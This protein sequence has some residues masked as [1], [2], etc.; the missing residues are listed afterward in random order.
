M[1]GYGLPHPYPP[2]MAASV[3]TFVNALASTLDTP[4]HRM[5]DSGL[6]RVLWELGCRESPLR[7]EHGRGGFNIRD[8]M[9]ALDQEDVIDRPIWALAYMF[10]GGLRIIHH[11]P[12]TSPL[13]PSNWP[14]YPYGWQHLW[15]GEL[16]RVR[17]SDGSARRHSRSLMRAGVVELA[18]MCDPEGDRYL[19]TEEAAEACPW[20]AQ[21]GAVHDYEY[22]RDALM[23]A[24]VQPTRGR[25]PW[26]AADVK[27]GVAPAYVPPDFGQHA[28][29][30]RWRFEKQT[31]SGDGGRAMADHLGLRDR[32]E[33]RP[34][35]DAQQDSDPSQMEG[36][37][38]AAAFQARRRATRQCGTCKSRISPAQINYFSTGGVGG[39]YIATTEKR[40]RRSARGRRPVR[41][42]ITMR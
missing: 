13:H 4:A 21:F 16:W 12:E 29:E 24:G 14:G 2:M 18:N 36:D 35:P 33:W 15:Y 26:P 34:E 23:T 39:R 40:P 10:D 31:R 28:R 7:D 27:R 3:A 30:Y 17:A 22:L 19:T 37:P 1:T 9:E 20:I 5:A 41:A 38:T 32:A 6:S 11:V 42:G 8:Q 25:T